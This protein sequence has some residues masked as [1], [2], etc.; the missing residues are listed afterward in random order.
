MQAQEAG[1]GRATRGMV[2]FTGNV[3]SR[4]LHR[5]ELF[6]GCPGRN[7]HS[8]ACLGPQLG[9]W[10]GHTPLC[11]EPLLRLRLLGGHSLAQPEGWA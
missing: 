9:P 7:T 6:A 4:L 3:Q 1:G 2:L 11:W 8:Q 10:D 5:R